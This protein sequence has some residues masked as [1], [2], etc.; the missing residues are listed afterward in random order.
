M[1]DNLDDLFDFLGQDDQQAVDGI[2]GRLQEIQLPE[3]YGDV[4]R[5]CREVAD[6][7]ADLLEDIG[8]REG[9]SGSD[10]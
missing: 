9:F 4:I 8:T 3:F 6:L 5:L 10:D 7:Y 1:A 2:L